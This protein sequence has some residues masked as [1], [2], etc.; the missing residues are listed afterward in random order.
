MRMHVGRSALLSLL[1]ITLAYGCTSGPSEEAVAAFDA[2]TE[3]QNRRAGRADADA[4]VEGFERAVEIDPDFAA[5]W[6]G[7]AQA[8]IWLE[9][10]QGVA[11]QLAP[12]EA[13]A[14]RAAELAP[15]A[16]ETHL[17]LGYIA[18]RGHGDL[19]GALEHFRAAEAQSAE[20]AEVAGAVGNILRRQGRLPEAIE[21]YE[22][23]VELDPTHAQGRA[24][25]A[26]TYAALGRYEDTRAAADELL[27]QG[28]GRAH[29][30]RFWSS[31]HAGDTAS[32]WSEIEGIQAAQGRAGQPGYFAFLQALVRRDTEG[33]DALIAEIGTDVGGNL[34]LLMA[35]HIAMTGQID[36]HADAFDGWIATIEAG[37]VETPTTTRER[38]QQAARLSDLAYLEA[39]RGDGGASMA[40]AAAAV[41]LDPMS[42]DAWAGSNTMMDVA[43][44]HLA[45][46]HANPGLAGIEALQEDGMGPTTGWLTLHPIFD[47]FRG[48]ERFEAILERRRALED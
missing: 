27:A 33:G 6:A 7:L 32:A 25:L 30:W 44:A 11:G 36:G 2:A 42:S 24:T 40:H 23:R 38:M 21:A 15:D 14:A 34:R 29:V 8:R 16:G 47:P 26:G 43:L 17:A 28:D 13:A 31:F 45:L 3:A 10:N 18:Y 9:F 19:D 35:D 12:A 1:T 4:A 20:D 39:R 46:D 22:R 37:L 5:A 41:D 48:D